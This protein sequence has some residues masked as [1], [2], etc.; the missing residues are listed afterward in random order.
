[1]TVTLTWKKRYPKRD[2][3]KALAGVRDFY[4]TAKD[5]WG[6]AQIRA[7]RKDSRPMWIFLLWKCFTEIE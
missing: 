4:P 7:R 3:P 5:T 2:R 6:G 1:M